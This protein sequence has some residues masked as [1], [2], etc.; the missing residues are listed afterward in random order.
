MPPQSQVRKCAHPS[1]HCLV[2]EENEY[3]SDYCKLAGADEHCGCGHAG[4]TAELNPE[5]PHKVEP[6]EAV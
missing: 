2:S 5:A 1:C 3:C 6:R 4:C